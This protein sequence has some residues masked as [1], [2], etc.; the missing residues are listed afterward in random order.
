[1][2][3]NNT[4]YR[5]SI[6]MGYN[7]EDSLRYRYML[8][9]SEIFASFWRPQSYGCPYYLCHTKHTA[10]ALHLINK[11]YTKLREISV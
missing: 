2:E 11:S 6:K 1:M 5:V 7:S 3:E 8:E 4:E 9:N 10:S